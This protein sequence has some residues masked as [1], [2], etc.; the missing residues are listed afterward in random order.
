MPNLKWKPSIY[1]GWF[2]NDEHGNRWYQTANREVITVV[3][4][5]GDSAQ[6]WTVEMA[7]DNLFSAA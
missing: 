4:P 3:T 5:E 2:A 1:G 7:W 6:G